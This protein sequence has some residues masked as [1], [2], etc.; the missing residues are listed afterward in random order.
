MHPKQEHKGKG[1]VGCC[2]EMGWGFSPWGLF[3]GN[4]GCPTIKLK[5]NMFKHPSTCT[6]KHLISRSWVT[7]VSCYDYFGKKDF[8][9]KGKKSQIGIFFAK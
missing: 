9:K 1:I 5:H 7:G 3:A 8:K 2:S 6:W 4:S